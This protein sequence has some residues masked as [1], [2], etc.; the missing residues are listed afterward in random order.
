MDADERGFEKELEEAERK[1]DDGTLISDEEKEKNR[2]WIEEI[3][4][5]T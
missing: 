2:V 3:E 4:G 1:R 5:R